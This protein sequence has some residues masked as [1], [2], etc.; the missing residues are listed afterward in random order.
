MSAKENPEPFATSSGSFCAGITRAE[1]LD[2]PHGHCGPDESES[3]RCADLAGSGAT[4]LAGIKHPN[5]FELQ[6]ILNDPNRFTLPR[7]TLLERK[8]V[9]QKRKKQGNGS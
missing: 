2:A 7:K 8:A 6:D 9:R 4:T 1:A 3:Q 5:A